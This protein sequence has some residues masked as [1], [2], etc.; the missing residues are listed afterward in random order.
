M[1]TV[2]YPP[3]QE[4]II[5]VKSD[6]WAHTLSLLSVYIFLPFQFRGC[7]TIRL[8]HLCHIYSRFLPLLHYV[9]LVFHFLSRAKPLNI[10]WF[11]WNSKADIRAVNAPDRKHRR[12]I[13]FS[14]RG[15]CFLPYPQGEN[16]Y[17]QHFGSGN[18]ALLFTLNSSTKLHLLPVPNH[19]LQITPEIIICTA[20]YIACKHISSLAIII[21]KAESW[22]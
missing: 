11:P 16:I 5:T 4:Q 2:F 21:I 1:E 13:S 3:Y 18:A 17:G 19:F 12:N 9:N 20:C 7:R 6:I 8:I 15:F 22:A 14:S 10:R